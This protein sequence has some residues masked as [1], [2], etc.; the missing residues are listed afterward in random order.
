MQ[1]RATGR[2]RPVGLHRVLEPAGR[3][4]R[5]RPRGWTP[6][7]E[8]W[9][10]EVRVAVETL[11]LDAA[12][13]PPAGRE[14]HR[15]RRRRRGRARRGARHRRHA[16]Q[17]AEP[18]HRLGRHAHRHRRG[19]RARVAARAW[20]VGDRVA[21]LV[22]LSLTPLAITDGLARWDG[23]SERV[24]AAGHAHPVRPLDRRP[25]CPRTSRPTLALMVMDVCGAPALVARVVR[26]V[27]RAR[28][29]A[30]P[31]RCSVARASRA[32]CPWPRPATPGPAAASASCRSSG[33][34]TCWRG[35]GWPMRW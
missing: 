16:R 22:S 11:N 2:P 25:S 4:C 12:S 32:R 3:R 28:R 24:P 33:R 23:R 6:A 5:R 27:R 15:Q 10:D 8:L 21:T 19:G 34:P 26:R 1:H 30:R 31:S 20:R 9:P 13:L 29:R 7:P 18:G 35:A 17:D 14:A